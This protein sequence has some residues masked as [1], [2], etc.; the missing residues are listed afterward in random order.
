MIREEEGRC[1][2]GEG[3]RKEGRSSLILGD[4]YCRFGIYV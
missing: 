2:R 3:G 1:Q 4:N